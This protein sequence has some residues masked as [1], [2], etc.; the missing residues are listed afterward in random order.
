MSLGLLWYSPDSKENTPQ[1]YMTVDMSSVNK[2]EA[3]LDELEA[4][5]I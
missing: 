3:A 1:S 2:E 4:E 5:D